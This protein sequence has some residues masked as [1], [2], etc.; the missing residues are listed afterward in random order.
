VEDVA[1]LSKTLD[2]IR[3]GINSGVSEAGAEFFE[4]RLPL[5]FAAANIEDASHRALEVILRN[6]QCE[7]SL[8]GR[9][10]RSDDA[11]ILI[12]IPPVEISPV[13][14]GTWP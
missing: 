4:G 6:G 8:A 7:E 11:V 9:L 10:G 1:A 5:A 14:G 13:I 12:S 2:G 3:A